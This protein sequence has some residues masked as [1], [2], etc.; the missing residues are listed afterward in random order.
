M[1][2][3]KSASSRLL[4]VVRRRDQLD[5]FVRALLPSRSPLFGQVSLALPDVDSSAELAFIRTASWL[6]VHYFEVG[7]VGVRFL[8]RRNIASGQRGRDHLD[9]VQALRTWSQHNIDPSTEHD[10]RIAEICETWFEHNCGTRVPRTE[11]H[12]TT[13]VGSLLTEAQGFFDFLLELLAAIEVDDDRDLI[14]QQWEDR[15]TRDW[16]AY[17]YHALIAQV[18][19]DLGRGALDPVAFYNRQGQVFREALRLVSDDA[20]LEAEARKQIERAM[21]TDTAAVLPITG[22]DVM[23]SYGISPGP[24]VGRILVLARRLYEEQP[25]DKTELLR[26]IKEAGTELLPAPDDDTEQQDAPA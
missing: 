19:A 16:P 5:S 15:L 9:L 22:Q 18:A 20:D 11:Q 17:R 21:L 24:Q 23:E 6:Y 2:S 3:I 1:T 26:R 7:R 4:D 25:C 13:L 10:A 8:V 14:C 12:W